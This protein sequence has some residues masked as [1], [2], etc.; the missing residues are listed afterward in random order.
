MSSGGSARPRGGT[1]SQGSR[2]CCRRRSRTGR[3]WRRCWRGCTGGSCGGAPGRCPGGVRR[4]CRRP[5]RSSGCVRSSRRRRRRWCASRSASGC[6]RRS[7]PGWPR[8]WIQSLPCARSPAGRRS[9]CGAPRSTIVAALVASGTEGGDAA[10]RTDLLIEA[11]D[12]TLA[13]DDAVALCRCDE[14][15]AG[16]LQ[17]A[18]TS[19][20]I[21][22]RAG[23]RAGFAIALA[24]EPPP[25]GRSIAVAAAP[26]ASGRSR[27]A[28]RAGAGAARRP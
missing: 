2:A 18:I 25:R 3:R 6:C 8:R 23:D 28:R 12:R 27:P 15:F 21:A 10:R 19:S 7:R 20:R 16:R 1:R 17:G 5:S 14:P 4:A 26:A 24:A 9:R 22:L 13:S 11:L